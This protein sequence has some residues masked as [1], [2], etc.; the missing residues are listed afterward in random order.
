LPLSAD[1]WLAIPDAD[2]RFSLAIWLASQY[3]PDG[4]TPEEKR[5]CCA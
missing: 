4:F 2:S 3:L 5:L 1:S